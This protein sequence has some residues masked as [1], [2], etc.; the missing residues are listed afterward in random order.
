YE[1]FSANYSGEGFSDMRFKFRALDAA[2]FQ[3]WL[4]AAKANG[5]TLSRERYL[6]LEKPS[7]KE[8]VRGFGPVGPGLFGLVVGRCVEPG[9]R[10]MHE[11]MALDARRQVVAAAWP[12]VRPADGP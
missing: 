5:E 10:C 4:Q 2:G 11:T 1:G 7:S 3:R 9:K 6:Q 12:T 8:A